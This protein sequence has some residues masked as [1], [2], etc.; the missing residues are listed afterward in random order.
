MKYKISQD[1]RIICTLLNLSYSEL[2]KELG[3]ARSTITRVVN[4]NTYPNDLFLEAFYS[5]AYKNK[6][7]GI[8]LNNLKAQFNQDKYSNILFHASKESIDGEIDL[9]HSR[10]DIDMGQGFYLGE[11]FEQAASYAF[12][13]KK[14]SIYVFDSSKLLDLKT[15]EYKVDL[16]WML[17]ISYFRGQLSQY[18]ESPIIKKVIKTTNEYDIIV[19]PIADN[20]M[21]DIMNRFARGDI[22]DLQA[23]SALSASHLGKQHVLKTKRACESLIIIDRLYLSNEERKDI[24]EMK[25]EENMVSI[26]KMRISIETYR[27]QGKYIEEIMNELPRTDDV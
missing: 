8:K 4:G 14:S 24:E 16:E 19:A 9:N 17:T 21:Y 7:R 25:K 5:F 26:D 23:I 15:K 6:Y 18:S 1:I 20:N 10:N 2:A 11:S 13:F 22:T 12:P 27:R 3:V